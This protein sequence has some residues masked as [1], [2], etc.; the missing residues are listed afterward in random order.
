VYDHPESEDDVS[1]FGIDVERDAQG[2]A[3]MILRNPARLNA[4]RFEMWEAIP[5]LV[6]ELA[7]DRAVRVIV[8]RGAGNEAFASGADISEFATHRKD[9]A[10]AAAYEQ[11]NGRA[12]AALL[13]LEKPLVAMIQGVCI[14]G[15]LAIAACADLRIASDDA[16]F[17]LPAAR[18]GLGYH[19]SG[20][21]RLV[22]LLGPSA[23]A[24]V[25]F[26][27]RQYTADEALR[28]GLVNRT[29]PRA[30]LRA[31][32]QRYTADIAA[33]APLT[34]RAA[35]RAILETQRPPEARDR[36]AVSRL[37]AACFESADYAEG[38]R[39]FLEKRR[40]AFR[41]T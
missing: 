14:G 13:A 33:N 24:E 25:F 8:L 40:P 4:V 5:G 30:E 32:T 28:I 15:G 12:F 38:V 11:V 41:G 39:A 7:A 3:W 34:L 2:I 36:A 26:T 1:E 31:F 18:L 17:A 19:Q 37:I 10:S 35:K 16:R 6:A 29:V 22:G 9:A 20:V 21:E 23:A 27:A